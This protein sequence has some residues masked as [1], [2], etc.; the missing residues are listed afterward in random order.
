[1]TL[2]VVLIWIHVDIAIYKRPEGYLG[3]LSTAPL[4]VSP[5]AGCG[6]A[7]G[8]QGEEVHIKPITGT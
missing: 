5:H 6:C 1:M 8:E 3:P 7:V 2:I 4:R